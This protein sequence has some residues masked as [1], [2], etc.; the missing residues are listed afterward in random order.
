VEL[1]GHAE[2]VADQQPVD[3]AP[4]PLAALAVTLPEGFSN[5]DAHAYKVLVNTDQ[6]RDGQP[7]QAIDSAIDPAIDPA[8]ALRIIQEQTSVSADRLGYSERAAFLSWGA[9]YLIG[10][11][12]LAL[13]IG[14]RGARGGVG[15]GGVCRV[16]RLH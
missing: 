10:Y 1:V 15:A 2:C 4:D 11:L 16:R 14:P 9:A 3:P 13:A 8:T 7:E 5:L 12:L 6:S